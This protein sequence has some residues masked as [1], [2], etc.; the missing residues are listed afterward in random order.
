MPKTISLVTPCF[1][2]E[3]SIAECYQAIKDLFAE[4]LPGYRREHVFCDNASTDRT[5]EVLKEL[6]AADPSVKIIVNSRN[7]GILRNTYN[8]V[9]STT[10]DA[11]VLFL[12]ADLQDPPELIPTFVKHWEAGNE[13]VFGIRAQREESFLL[14]SARHFY[15]QFI[16]RM[17]YVTYPADVGDFQLVDRKV[18]EAMRR[19]DDVQPFMR[20]MPF[21]AGFRSI[22]VPYTWQPRKRGVSRNR[23]W[24]LVDQGLNGIISF[25]SAPLR[26]AFFAGLGIAL[27]SFLFAFTL[28]VLKLLNFDIGPQGIP[29]IV[30]AIF[31]FGG[32][33]M[34]FLGLLGEY[35]VAIFNQVRR[36]PIVIERERINFDKTN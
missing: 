23:L 6:A 10:G 24:Q 27:C 15:Y 31:F 35:I 30:I 26:I 8:G 16:S 5:V 22:G 4:K 17:S 36:R 3:E 34:L 11:I 12:P 1:N 32:V 25:S 13:V 2:E 7:F 29:T 21:D 19:F 14:R 28:L 20:M 9:L 18:L 33:Q